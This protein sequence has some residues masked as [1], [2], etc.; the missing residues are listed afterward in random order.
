MS[1]KYLLS[2]LTIK[3][4]KDHFWLFQILMWLRF[5]YNI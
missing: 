5:K 3:Y 4:E 1:E 2:Y